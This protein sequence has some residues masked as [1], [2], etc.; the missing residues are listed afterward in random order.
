MK[1]LNI[2]FVGLVLFFVT[3]AS[4]AAIGME[5]LPELEPYIPE[6]LLIPSLPPD[7]KKIIASTTLRVIL[8]DLED[9][10]KRKKEGWLSMFVKDPRTPNT[11]EDR[12]WRRYRGERE[13]VSTVMDMIM[14]LIENGADPNIKNY[15]G[16]TALHLI[17]KD[18]VHFY[19]IAP[20]EKQG[21]LERGYA[22]KLTTEDIM[23]LLGV[24]SKI[25]FLVKHNIDVNATNNEG[26]T[27]AHTLLRNAPDINREVLWSFT[28]FLKS[29][30]ADMTIKNNAGLTPCE[31]V[32]TIPK[33]IWGFDG[34]AFYWS[35]EDQ[36]NCSKY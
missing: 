23:R 29:V 15:E 10:D 32:K 31:L 25:Q 1:K 30:G 5:E 13:T 8:D 16:N 27:A 3:F 11:F 20:V 22:H 21:F 9:I 28:Q 14:V 34:P 17:F 4:G 19:K 24:Q 2:K 26:D 18:I 12:I 36:E 7:V 33:D 6:E 35:L